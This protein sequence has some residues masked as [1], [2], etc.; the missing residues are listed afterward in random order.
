M[1]AESGSSSRVQKATPSDVAAGSART[2]RT[3]TGGASSDTVTLVS[4][5]GDGF[6]VEASAIEVSKLLNAMVDGSTENA[7]KE[8]PLPNMRSNVVA[9]V[10]EFCQHHQTDP[11][12][13]IP[14]AS[15]AS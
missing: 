9:K 12:T 7:A 8:I 4:M 1:A 5:D 15:T 10:V 3:D 14:K 2:T 11:M 13:D 6:V